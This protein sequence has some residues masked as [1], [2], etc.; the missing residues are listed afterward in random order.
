[1][2]LKNFLVQRWGHRRLRIV[3]HGLTVIL[4]LLTARDDLG[5]LPVSALLSLD[6]VL[7]HIVLIC[8]VLVEHVLRWGLVHYHVLF[9]VC[10]ILLV[11]CKLSSVDIGIILELTVRIRVVSVLNKILALFV[12]IK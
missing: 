2:L 9:S 12:S 3:Y 10:S 7:T 4:F 8:T 5:A 1:M 6:N 11:I